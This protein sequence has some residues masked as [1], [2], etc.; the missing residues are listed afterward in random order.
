[1]RMCRG[2]AAMPTESSR[3]SNSRVRRQGRHRDPM[4]F[5]QGPVLPSLGP[6]SLHRGPTLLTLGPYITITEAYIAITRAVYC[7]H[8]GGYITITGTLYYSSP[9]AAQLKAVLSLK[10]RAVITI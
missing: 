2:L 4:F 7:S 6:I 5:T 9:T 8:W 1:M 10:P 3:A